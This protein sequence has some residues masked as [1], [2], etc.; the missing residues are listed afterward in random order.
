MI[1]IFYHGK[2]LRETGAVVNDITPMPRAK[3]N[4][5]LVTVPGRPGTLHMIDGDPGAVTRTVSLSVRSKDAMWRVNAW[6]QRSGILRV[7]DEPGF[8]FHAYQYDEIEWE[9]VSNRYYRTD[10]TFEL[11]PF[12][13]MD[14]GLVPIVCENDNR[15]ANPGNE[16]SAPE[17]TLAAT[18]NVTLYIGNQI[19]YI[20]SLAEGIVI[21]S[22]MQMAHWNGASMSSAMQG[23]Y[24]VLLPGMNHIYWIGAVTKLSVVPRWRSL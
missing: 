12:R 14:I 7:T 6:C 24:P 2:S 20:T 9:K 11:S 18:G 1:D 4:I 10:I 21:D 17:L 19:V 23:N 3:R 5:S 22:D 8:F 15:I 16:S 13:N